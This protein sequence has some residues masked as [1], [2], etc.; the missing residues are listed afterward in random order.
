M[1][2]SY[3]LKLYFPILFKDVKNLKDYNEKK[4]EIWN[5][6]KTKLK[7]FY[8]KVNDRVDL[9]YNIYNKW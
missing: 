6:D 4:F 8:K 3:F 2:E 9:F 1:N 5:N 7:K